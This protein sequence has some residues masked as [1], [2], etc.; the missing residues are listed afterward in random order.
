MAES[1]GL[2]GWANRPTAMII[3]A[4]VF[5]IFAAVLAGFYIKLR[6]DAYLRSLEGREEVERSVVV[7]SQDLPRGTVVDA[8]YFSVRTVNES[9]LH[10]DA[11]A[12]SSFDAIKG[13]VLVED[14]RGGTPLLDSFLEDSFPVSFS[15]TLEPGR[16]AITIQVDELNSIGGLARAGDTIDVY[17]LI[18]PAVGAVG[19]GVTPQGLGDLDLADLASN[20]VM[21]VLQGVEVL[22]A[23]EEVLEDYQEKL[24][25]RREAPTTRYS[26]V[27]IDVS[28]REGALISQAI[29][30]GDLITMLRNR[31]DE[32]KADFASVGISDLFANAQLLAIQ[33]REERKKALEQGFVVDEDGTVRLAT[34]EVVE[35]AVVNEGGFIVG[36]DGQVFTPDGQVIEGA[37]VDENG[38]VVAPNGEI[39]VA[40]EITVGPDGKVRKLDGTQIAGLSGE[41]IADSDVATVVAGLTELINESRGV[42]FLAGGNSKDGIAEVSEL[43]VLE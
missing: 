41:S 3:A 17:V 19:N 4:V 28:A 35:G 30:Q 9:M 34:G 38:N 6:G 2:G 12:P 22:A 24:A 32:T 40:S 36:P 23:G 27:T 20:V 7:A 26:N 37:T 42:S 5:G 39:L 13:R 8:R 10:R 14:M 11:V 1:K 16:R 31:D 43:P 25:F 21:P 18:S 29:D 15:D 33:A